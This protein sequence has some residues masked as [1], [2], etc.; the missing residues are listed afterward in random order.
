MRVLSLLLATTLIAAGY[1]NDGD[2]PEFVFPLIKEHGGVV[3]LPQAVQPARA[4]AKLVFD[5]TREG[6]ADQ[7][8]PGLERAARYLNLHALA[9]HG[10]DEVQI[11][12]VFHGEATKVALR[13][14]VY[15]DATK[16]RK[17][18]NLELVRQ[19]MSA[20]VEVLVCGQSLAR[21]SYRAKDVAPEFTVAVS[22]MTV[23]V[24][25]QLDGYAYLPIH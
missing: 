10:A 18:P 20:G 6:N 25:K 21:N 2:K 16:S 17:N 22:A 15:A 3:A 19:L 4:G 24:N 13:D 12:L 1:G 5:I 14:E 23:S 11:A 7:V 9:G 8:H